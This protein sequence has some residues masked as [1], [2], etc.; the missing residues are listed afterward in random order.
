MRK[1]GQIIVG[2]ALIVAGLLYML[3]YLFDV[4]I[5]SFIW[6]L[7]LIALGV[8]VIMRPRMVSEG[9]EVTVKLLGD[10]KRDGVWQVT[11]EEVWLLLGDVKVDMTQAEIPAGETSLCVY[12]LI[13]DI[14]LI[15][16]H[17][18]GVSLMST[19]FVSDVKAL[20]QKQDR[21]LSP[22][23]MMSDGYET[24]ECKIR[25]QVIAFIADVKVEQV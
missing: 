4:S 21:F 15:V 13:A 24:A 11:D 9:T 22:A 7:A 5:W 1:N 19:A 14:K 3:G 10:V 23:R 17:D 6:P 16:P 2:V 20:G 18:V 25:L 12:G 8:W